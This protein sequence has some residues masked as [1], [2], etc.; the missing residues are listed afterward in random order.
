MAEHAGQP[1]GGVQP[2][3]GG[4]PPR[5]QE[6]H[7]GAANPEPIELPELYFRAR[8]ASPPC[9]ALLGGFH[10]PG[11]GGLVVYSCP[12]C[13]LTTVFKN[14][15]FGIKSRLVGPLVGSKACPPGTTKLNGAPRRPRGARGGRGR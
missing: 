4:T 11:I 5:V 3:A 13:G 2:N 1:N 6:A 10:I 8:C 15:A 14:E 9:K 12:M 7:D